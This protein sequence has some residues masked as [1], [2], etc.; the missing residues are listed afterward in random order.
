MPNSAL[1]TAPPR[2]GEKS[3]TDPHRAQLRRLVSAIGRHPVMTVVVVAVLARVT[4]VLG[5]AVLAD[6][7]LFQDDGTYRLM[8][9]QKAFGKTEGWD[10][11]TRVLYDQTAT[12]LVPLTLLFRTFGSAP[13]LGQLLVAA[14]AVAAAAAITRVALISLPTPFAIA[15][16]SV[17]ALMPSQVLFS[18]LLL[19]DAPVWAILS[20]LALLVA[21]TLRARPVK[22]AAT[23]VSAVVLL[24][25]LAHL[26]LHTLVVACWALALA[27]LLARGSARRRAALAAAGLGILVL[28][29][30]AHALG[31]AGLDL[32]RNGAVT[33]EERR[34]AN[35]AGAATA[36]VPPPR[37]A[38]APPSGTDRPPSPNA[39]PAPPSPGGEDA[40][41]GRRGLD[42]LPRGL[43]VILLEP[44]PWQR[45]HNVQMKL[46]LAEN[47]IWWPLLGLAAFGLTATWRH[48][49]VLAFPALA[50]GAT[51]F[52]YALSEG[53]F[54]TAY[55]HR[56]EFVWAAALLAGFGLSQLYTLRN[57]RGRT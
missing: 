20:G 44:Y 1:R 50:G 21:A 7:S 37:A 12:L 25:L 24:Q 3:V 55:R 26:R 29:P 36:F 9:E 57:S 53:N 56:G 19:K 45:L 8:A 23:L 38:G 33:L 11:Y 49:D 48:R 15:T 39:S 6:G 27:L 41:S 5:F 46:A 40:A 14:F 16:G 10:E 34:T 47:L 13:V 17:V 31:P 4:V 18:S 51:V 30:L 54:G 28:M 22:A 2:V 52:L 43:S 35:A 42:A 32:V